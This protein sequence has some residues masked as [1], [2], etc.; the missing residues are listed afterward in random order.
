MTPIV[1]IFHNS[2]FFERIIS[3]IGLKSGGR[4]SMLNLIAPTVSKAW[5]AFLLF[6]IGHPS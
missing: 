2:Y 1:R 4:G 5:L 3:S 6:C